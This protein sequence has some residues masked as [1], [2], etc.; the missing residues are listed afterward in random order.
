MDALYSERFYRRSVNVPVV[1][2]VVLVLIAG[3]SAGFVIVM[4]QSDAPS[5]L[6]SGNSAA[7]CQE[8]YVSN[9]RC[10]ADGYYVERQYSY[11]NCSLQW[12]Q[13][14]YCPDGCLNSVCL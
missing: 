10:S 3:F 12:R 5:W 7:G 8:Q 6:P 1:L 14:Q 2:L 9:F 4:V 13:F 11:A